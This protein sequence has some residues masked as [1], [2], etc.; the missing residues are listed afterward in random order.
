[1]QMSFSLAISHRCGEGSRAAQLIQI[2]RVLPN[3]CMRH[4]LRLALGTRLCAGWRDDHAR[5]PG[6]PSALLIPSPSG[7]D[8]RDWPGFS[9]RTS[10]CGL[11]R[12]PS[13]LPYL[14]AA[15]RKAACNTPIA[16]RLCCLGPYVFIWRYLTGADGHGFTDPL[17]T[18]LLIKV[19]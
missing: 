16:G 2:S 11:V 7:P 4:S 14:T 13:A 8:P 18:R 10:R 5:G 12:S 6:Q 15:F 19:Y 3:G 17:E 9:S 1:M